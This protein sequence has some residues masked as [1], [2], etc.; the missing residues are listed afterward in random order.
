MVLRF[1]HRRSPETVAS[2]EW[3][4]SFPTGR[5]LGWLAAGVVVVA[6]SGGCASGPSK[7]GSAA[8][9]VMVKAGDTTCEVS[10]TSLESGRHTFSIEN[11]AGRVSEV[12]VYGAGD[13]VIGE[14]DNIS[15]NA[16]R[17]LIVDL[18]AGKYQVAC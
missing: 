9:Q 8:G 7:V 13:Q 16:T 17:D 11:T 1:R 14:V 18:P 6:V 3:D 12:Y 5:V 15:P 2:H 10:A 4:P